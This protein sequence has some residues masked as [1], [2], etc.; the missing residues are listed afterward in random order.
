MSRAGHVVGLAADFAESKEWA[1]TGAT[2]AAHWIAGTADIEVG[3]A[4]EWIRVGK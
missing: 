2:T 1:V 4:R 3:T